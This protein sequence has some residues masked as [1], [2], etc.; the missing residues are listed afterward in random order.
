MAPTSIVPST[1]SDVLS[2]G[3]N[4]LRVRWDNGHF[5]F[6]INGTE[7]AT[8]DD[9]THVSG[10]VGLMVSEGGVIAFDDFTVIEFE[11]EPLLKPVGQL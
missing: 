7:V 9:T 2:S 1:R 11:V 3:A 6:F 8:V 4:R 10:K 5:S